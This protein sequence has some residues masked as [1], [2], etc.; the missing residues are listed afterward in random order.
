MVEMICAKE[1]GHRSIHRRTE[2]R[3]ILRS[4]ILGP[5]GSTGWSLSEIRGHAGRR[6]QR[7]IRCRL[8]GRRRQGQHLGIGFSPMEVTTPR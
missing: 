5:P 6:E 3:A 7:A 8:A 4:L 2:R 1:E